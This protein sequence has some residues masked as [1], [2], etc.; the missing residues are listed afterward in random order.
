[1][2]HWLHILVLAVPAAFAQLA[3]PTPARVFVGHSSAVLSVAYNPLNPNEFISGSQDGRVIMWD[4]AT[5]NQLQSYAV[6]FPV[7]TVAYSPTDANRFLSAGD[8]ERVTEWNRTGKVMRHALPQSVSALAWFP[9]GTEFL[10]GCDNGW[11]YRYPV[12]GANTS[13]YN[14]AA[15]WQVNDVAIDPFN[16]SSFAS[17]GVEKIVWLWPSA[18]QLRA[19]TSAVRSVAYDTF[20]ANQLFSGGTDNIAVLWQT[21]VMVRN[22]SGHSGAVTVVRQ[23]A[24]NASLLVTASADTTIRFWDKSSGQTVLTLSNHSGAVNALAFN[25]ANPNEFL[26][27][28]SDKTI[29]LWTVVAPASPSPSPPSTPQST[30]TS[31]SPSPPSP[32]KSFPI[33]W[34][35]VIAIVVALLVA[36][37][38]GWRVF[39]YCGKG[40]AAGTSSLR[41]K[42]Q[43]D[44]QLTEAAEKTRME[45]R[46]LA[47][48]AADD[49]PEGVEGLSGE[50]GEGEEESEPFDQTADSLENEEEE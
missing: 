44:Q 29:V 43:T 41:R 19:H 25:P 15:M 11:I 21:G 4:K 36:A 35:I 14:R 31:P 2:V 23:H 39:R 49:V 6:H 37:C 22:Y 17:A 5:G 32:S 26:S 40:A 18:T 33:L 48:G 45:E 42:T 13:S 34:V 47:A 46:Q 1:M 38:V 30:G 10:A 24:G 9:S 28:S 16:P 12:G 27:A 3:Q 50:A 20:V 7:K 8:D